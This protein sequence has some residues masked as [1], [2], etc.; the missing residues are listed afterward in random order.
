MKTKKIKPK[1]KYTL[2]AFVWIRR[3]DNSGNDKCCTEDVDVKTIFGLC[4]YTIK[5]LTKNDGV[6]ILKN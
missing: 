1:Y 4:F 3:K 6:T 5:L 2:D